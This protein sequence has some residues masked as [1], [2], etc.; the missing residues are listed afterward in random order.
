MLT[1]KKKHNNN[2]KWKDEVE[3]NGKA[4]ETQSPSRGVGR[5]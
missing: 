5:Q 3:K 2:K 1:L 4:K